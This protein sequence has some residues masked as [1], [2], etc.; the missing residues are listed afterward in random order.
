VL[1][2]SD[3]DEEGFRWDAVREH[4]P[5]VELMIHVDAHGVITTVQVLKNE[6]REDVRDRLLKTGMNV[7]NDDDRIAVS[8]FRAKERRQALERS[9]VRFGDK[10]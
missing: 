3:L 4:D 2:L 6:S 9:G 1:T 8:H 5:W 7:L 10:K